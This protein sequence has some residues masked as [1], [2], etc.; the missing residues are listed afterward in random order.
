VPQLIPVGLLVTLPAPL[1]ALVTVRVTGN[2]L[3]LA[4]TLT[5]MF[6]VTVQDAVPEH[7]PVQPLNFEPEAAVAARLTLVPTE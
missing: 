2:A 5:A 3:K 7:A 1:P 4:V 6:E